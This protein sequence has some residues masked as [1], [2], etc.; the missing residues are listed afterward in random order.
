MKLTRRDW[1]K[2]GLSAGAL[3][4]VPRLF[5]QGASAPAANSNLPLITKPIPS[6]GERIPVVG[7]GTRTYQGVTDDIRGVLTGLAESG[8]TMVDTADNYAGGNSEAVIG[9]ITQGAGVRDK[10]FLAT[11]VNARGEQAGREHLE[12]S[13]RKLRT[14]KID[15][16]YVHNLVDTTTQLK[17]LR[18]LKQAGRV[19]Y[20][21][22]TT[23]SDRQYADMESVMRNEQLDF[24]QLDYAI[25]NRTA[26]ERLLP[27]ALERKIAI[28]TNLPFGRASLFGKVGD[29]PL[30]DWAAEFDCKSW[31]QFFLKYNVSHPAITVAIPGTT[32]PRHLVDNVQGARGR[33]PSAAQRTRMEQFMASL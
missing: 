11:K 24:V 14:D 9:E 16:I 22:V 23:S 7:I 8:C 4:T 6:S 33:L 15:L 17:T 27:L 3:T 13:F 5:S 2:L 28:V 10:L 32:R 12:A 29:R 18:E 19:R 25:D 30:P 31:A 21:G 26:E 1:M 20:I